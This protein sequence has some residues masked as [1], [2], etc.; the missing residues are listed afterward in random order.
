MIKC[1]KCS[2]LAEPQERYCS[3]CHTVFPS[4]TKTAASLRLTAG[5]AGRW[6]VPSLVFIALLGAGFAQIDVH[7]ASAEAGSLQA[8][9]RDAKRAAIE[10]VAETTGFVSAP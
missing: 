9:A 8:A 6:K 5:S 10:W 1:P 3:T 2:R 7:D 4:D